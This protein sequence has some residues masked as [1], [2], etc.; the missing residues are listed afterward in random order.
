MK[1]AN[2]ERLSRDDWI[3]A[4]LDSLKAGGIE[5]VRVERLAR[6][7]GV[8]K[9]SFYWHFRDR[10]ALTRAMLDAWE[11][12]STDAVIAFSRTT[13]RDPR[14]RLR[15]VLEIVAERDARIDRAIRGWAG[16]DADVAEKVAAVDRRRLE[17]L[18]GVFREMG[19]GDPHARARARLVYTSMIGDHA[20][21]ER[22][23]SSERKL[24]AE[25]T[26]ALLTCD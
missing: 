3:D 20:V 6:T 14:A 18:R 22:A 26:Y 9:G 11:H 16:A 2:P 7:L 24:L 25:V 17:F 15:Q 5:A 13:C 19:F 4:G 1:D 10:A 12:Q 21:L 23:S 8:S